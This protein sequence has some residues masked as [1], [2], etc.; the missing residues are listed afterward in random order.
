[1]SWTQP[2]LEYVNIKIL[3]KQFCENKTQ[4]EMVFEAETKNLVFFFRIFRTS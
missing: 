2:Y 3:S 1:M 4:I